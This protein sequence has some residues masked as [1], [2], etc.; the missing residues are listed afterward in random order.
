MKKKR[1]GLIVGFTLIA[2]AVFFYVFLN[3]TRWHNEMFSTRYPVQDI[4]ISHYQEVIDLEKVSQENIDFVFMKATEGHDYIDPNFEYN[5]EETDRLGIKRGAYHFFSMR[6]S[7]TDQGEKI[8]E[9]VPYD[10]NSM[11]PVIDIEIPTTHTEGV[12]KKELSDLIAVLKDHYHK[13]PILYVT[14]YTYNAY[15]NAY[16]K[17]DFQNAP[18]WIR[19]ILKP[20]LLYGGRNWTFWQFPDQGRINGINGDVDKNVYKSTQEQFNETFSK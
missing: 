14:Y 9:V 13:E 11:P 6:S 15:I 7:G 12:V 3:G 1:M 20:P 8:I 4:D 5:W 18:I 19:D 2:L 17:D 16:I 10:E